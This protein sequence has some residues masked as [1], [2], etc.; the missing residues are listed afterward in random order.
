MIA[1]DV[2]DMDEIE[3]ASLSERGSSLRKSTADLNVTRAKLTNR[4][5]SQTESCT[6][7]LVLNMIPT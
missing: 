6:M 7:L 3:H 2:E 4:S 5:I 1:E